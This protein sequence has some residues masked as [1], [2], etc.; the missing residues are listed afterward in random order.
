MFSSPRIDTLE[1]F[2]THLQQ[3]SDAVNHDLRAGRL[4]SNDAELY[5]NREERTYA[6]FAILAPHQI[7][8]W[9]RIRPDHANA[10]AIFSLELRVSDISS[11]TET[12][13]SINSFITGLSYYASVYGFKILNESIAPLGLAN[14]ELFPTLLQVARDGL[15]TSVGNGRSRQSIR[16]LIPC[17]VQFA[18]E[19]L[20][21][22]G[23]APEQMQQ[24]LARI[25]AEGTDASI[26]RSFVESVH[27]TPAQLEAFLIQ[28]LTASVT[29][30]DTSERPI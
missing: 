19:G 21:H 3:V 5:R 26:V 12:I 6:P 17:L 15:D 13:Q 24:E 22:R 11:N 16:S 9:V 18:S 2:E 28:L 7:Y 25:L 10:D 23:I 1:Q 4:D 30:S 14:A 20:A 29:K 27:A 8:S